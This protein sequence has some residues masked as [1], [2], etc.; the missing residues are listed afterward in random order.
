MVKRRPSPTDE[1]IERIAETIDSLDFNDQINDRESFDKFYDDYLEE[2]DELR[3]NKKVKTKV[4]DTLKNFHPDRIDGI[5][6]IPIKLKEEIAKEIGLFRI[7]RKQKGK[8][9]FARKD[10]FKVKN[11]VRVVFRDKHGKFT[12]SR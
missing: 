9:V 3:D 10:S 2:S 7:P 6:G 5:T 12:G 1:D 4:F 8:I 11:K